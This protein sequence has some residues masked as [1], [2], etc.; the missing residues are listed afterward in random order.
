LPAGALPHEQQ[1]P[2]NNAMILGTHLLIL[3]L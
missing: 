2:E 3:Q 1:P